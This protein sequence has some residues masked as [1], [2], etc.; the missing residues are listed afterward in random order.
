MKRSNVLAMIPDPV[1]RLLAL[2]LLLAASG[3]TVETG[4]A[5][6]A[7]TLA[8]APA[9]LD[10]PRAA[11]PP[12]RRLAVDSLATEPV[13]VDT[14]AMPPAGPTPAQRR[15]TAA[16]ALQTLMDRAQSADAETLV[17][18][19]D[20]TD[21]QLAALPDRSPR[22]DSLRQSIRRAA[23]RGDRAAVALA[24]ARTSRAL[25]ASQP[26]GDPA[27]LRADAQ[28]VAA[29]ASSPSPDWRALRTA[30]EAL[31]ARWQEAQ[32][33]VA[34]PAVRDA[35]ASAVAGVE[36]GSETQNAALSRLGADVVVRWASPVPAER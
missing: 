14:S 9:V 28:M 10:E 33:G 2:A 30:S 31:A 5:T 13:V 35:L 29:L 26:P 4:P 1:T 24:A 19:A 18:V 15:A 27:R 20:A 25:A 21:A 34:D 32:E 3:C 36:A 8:T 11:R 6:S 22:V 16:G 17:R 23:Q 12:A 7:D